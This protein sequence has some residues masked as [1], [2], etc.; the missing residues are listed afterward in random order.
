MQTRG[1]PTPRPSPCFSTAWPG[2]PEGVRCKQCGEKRASN[3]QSLHAIQGSRSGEKILI[4]VVYFAR[5]SFISDG[6]LETANP[7]WPNPPCSLTALIHSFMSTCFMSSWLLCCHFI[8]STRS[9]PDFRRMR[10]SG[11]YF[12][13]HAGIRIKHLK[14]AMVVFYPCRNRFVSIQLKCLGRFP[15]AVEHT[16]IAVTFL[17]CFYRL[18]VRHGRIS[19]VAR[20]G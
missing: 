18:P 6:F 17:G 15:S 16:I 8:S 19:A 7:H 20:M 4:R 2:S 5:M 3:G 1:W 9:F 11:W 12:F 10:K 13:H 14:T